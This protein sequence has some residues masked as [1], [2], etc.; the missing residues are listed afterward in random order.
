MKVSAKALWVMRDAGGGGRGGGEGHARVQRVVLAGK[1]GGVRVV[2]CGCMVGSSKSLHGS[3]QCGCRRTR[4]RSRV[5]ARSIRR[6][7]WCVARRVSMR[8]ARARVAVCGR[9]AAVH[10]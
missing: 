5:W 1:G 8:M 4:S 9:C 3:A 7:R 2:G 6:G 10:L